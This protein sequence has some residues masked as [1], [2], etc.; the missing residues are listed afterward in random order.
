ML[1]ETFA[2]GLIA[3]IIGVLLGLVVAPLLAALMSRPRASTSARPGSSS[4]PT[5]SSSA[6]SIG[7][8]ATMVAGFIPARRATRVEPVTAMRDAVTPGLGHLRTRRIVG[9]AVLMVLG[10]LVMFFGLFG[11]ASGSA[12]AGVHRRSARC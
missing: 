9:S 1:I 10:L 2:V 8:L 3:S 4:S 12:A 5:R 6:W 11:G 7:L